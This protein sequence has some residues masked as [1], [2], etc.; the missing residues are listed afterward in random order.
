MFVY[1]TKHVPVGVISCQ[2]YT[3]TKLPPESEKPE[4]NNGV[5]SSNSKADDHN[6]SECRRVVIPVVV[7]DVQSASVDI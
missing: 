6:S 5:Q 7:S 2:G 1:G 3:V 4:V